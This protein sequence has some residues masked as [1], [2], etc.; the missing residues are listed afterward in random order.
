MYFPG[1]DKGYADFAILSFQLFGLRLSSFYL[2]WFVLLGTS[3]VMFVASFWRSESR[4]TLLA[5]ALLGSYTAFFV[6]PLT[7][8]LATVQN[9]RAFGIVSI[10][11][12]LHICLFVLDGRR[13]T[14]GAV[15]AASAQVALIVFSIH[16]RSTEVWQVI[17]VGGVAMAALTRRLLGK[18]TASVWPVVLLIVGVGALRTY[19]AQAIDPAASRVEVLYRRAMWGTTSAWGSALNPGAVKKYALTVDDRTTSELVRE[20]LNLHRSHRNG[21]GV[22]ALGIRR[23][24]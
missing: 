4:L 6:L 9:P 5:L 21:S 22:P 15:V 2:T 10:V 7:S 20:Y 23:T 17:C 18:G 3:V 24:Y 12:V 1:D 16:V 19:N 11:A 14:L 8:E 13:F